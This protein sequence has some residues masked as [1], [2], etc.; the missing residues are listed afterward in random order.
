MA[1]GFSV[2]SLGFIAR[3]ILA[4]IIIAYL[5][6][7][8]SSD[9]AIRKGFVLLIALGA[10]VFVVGII[11]FSLVFITGGAAFLGNALNNLQYYF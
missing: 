9:P 3:F 8:D 2:T 4:F 7:K 6:S 10:A 11:I 1:F 5:Y